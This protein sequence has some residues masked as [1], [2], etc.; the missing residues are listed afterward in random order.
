MMS[1]NIVYK[2]ITR[3]KFWISA[4]IFMAKATLEFV[5]QPYYVI[6]GFAYILHS[7]R[8]CNNKFYPKYS[9][10]RYFKQNYKN[11]NYTDKY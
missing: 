2:N 11:K 5:V 7:M 9:S 6:Y 3:L 4:I 10:F 1:I 8:K